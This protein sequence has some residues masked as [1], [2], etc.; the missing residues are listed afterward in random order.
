MVHIHSSCYKLSSDH[1][2]YLINKKTDWSHFQNPVSLI[3]NLKLPLKT[4]EDSI[5][6]VEH[7]NSYVQ[8]AA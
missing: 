1:F 8:Q 4:S 2:P 5:V 3:I 6:A 7:F